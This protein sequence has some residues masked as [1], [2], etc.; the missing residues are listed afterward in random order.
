MARFF[1]ENS[2]ADKPKVVETKFRKNLDDAN[3]PVT[4]KI[5]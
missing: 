5:Q 3:A 4:Y 2:K 1:K